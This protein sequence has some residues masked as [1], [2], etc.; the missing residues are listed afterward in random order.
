MNH[1]RK[2]LE[3]SPHKPAGLEIILQAIAEISDCAVTCEAC[4]DACLGEE[5]LKRLSK[6]I[7]LLMDCS[8]AC[9]NTA[10]T[11]ARP[12]NADRQFLEAQLAACIAICD[13]CGAECR[14]HAKW[15]EHCKACAEA[16]DGCADMCRRL[17]SESDSLIAAA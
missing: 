3:S 7:R 13:S 10:A 15:H 6:C 1:V 9:R 14:M 17:S 11:L 5:N 4:S 8:G 16:C 12:G 2:V